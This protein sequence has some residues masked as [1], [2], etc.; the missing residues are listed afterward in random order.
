MGRQRGDAAVTAVLRGWQAALGSGGGWGS[1]RPQ[2]GSVHWAG[3]GASGKGWSRTEEGPRS[4]RRQDTESG[5]R[6]R[7]RQGGGREG[8]PRARGHPRGSTET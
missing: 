7:C 8:G 4:A 2:A 1:P 3:A 5:A 6:P